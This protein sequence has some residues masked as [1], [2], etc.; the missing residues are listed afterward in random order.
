MPAEQER[1]HDLLTYNYTS[2]LRELAPDSG[3]YINE[4]NPSEPDHQHAFWGNNYERLLKIKKKIDP[5]GLF[6]CAFCV[7][8]EGWKAIGGRVCRV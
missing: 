8:G 1:K 2:Y 5:T 3:S 7:G 6:W 4:A